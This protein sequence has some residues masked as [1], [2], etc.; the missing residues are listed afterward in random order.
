[1]SR[2]WILAL[3]A[4]CICAFALCAFAPPSFAESTTRQPNT[5]NVPLFPLAFERNV[6]QIDQQVRFLSH[7]PHSSVFLTPTEMVLTLPD[8]ANTEQPKLKVLRM[9]WA[10]ASVSPT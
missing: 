6:G 4:L 2:K 9:S 3:T 5:T 7:G 8:G 10:G 1:M